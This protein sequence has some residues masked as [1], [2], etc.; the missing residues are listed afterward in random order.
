MDPWPRRAW[1]DAK[2]EKF[3]KGPPGSSDMGLARSS[4]LARPGG[5]IRRRAESRGEGWKGGD[6]GSWSQ[7]LAG[8]AACGVSRKV[9]G[10][11]RRR[12]GRK[13]GRARSGCWK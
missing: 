11:G 13:T 8:W 12:C 3:G 2:A 5:E 6:S 1:A 7:K 9:V 10:L 4:R